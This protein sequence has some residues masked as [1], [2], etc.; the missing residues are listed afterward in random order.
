M[1][2]FKHEDTA[3]NLDNVS[4]FYL[5]NIKLKDTTEYGI[6]FVFSDDLR[7][8][9]KYKSEKSRDDVINN[10]WTHAY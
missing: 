5:E 4:Y 6:I 9:I 8:S 1:K 10:F 7:K 3:I 2:W